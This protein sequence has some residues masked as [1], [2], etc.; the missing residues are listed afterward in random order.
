MSTE[1]TGLIRIVRVPAGD[2]PYW[3][4]KEW[5]GLTL[6]CHHV[7]AIMPSDNVVS[8]QPVQDKMGVSVP[9]KEAL[10]ILK[11]RN[12]RAASWW[13]GAGFPQPPPNDCF[14][15]GEGEFKI[16]RGVE[17]QRIRQ[18]VGRLEI[19]DGAADGQPD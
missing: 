18:F 4:K 5:V 2:A 9:H 11:K 16:V 7:M 12:K 17:R 8:G 10:E 19:G 1:Y 3:V 6:P 15:F 14:L 13:E